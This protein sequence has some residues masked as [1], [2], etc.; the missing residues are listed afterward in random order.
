M[1]DSST[2]T[3]P[4]GHPLKY[5]LFLGWCILGVEGVLALTQDGDGIDT[6]GDLD[7]QGTYHYVADTAGLCH[8][9]DLEVIKL[10]TS[11]PSE[12]T[13][14]CDEFR[15]DL[16]KRDVCC[17][18]TGAAKEYGVG[19]HIIPY[20]RGSEWFRLIV[21][22][23]P[24]YGEQVTGLD[25]IN[26]VRNGMFANSLMHI[27]FN[28]RCVAILKTPNHILCVDDI[29]PRTVRSRLV[30]DVS[31]PTGSRYTLQWLETPDEF[32]A[33]DNG[34]AAFKKHTRM[35]KPSDLLLHYNYGAAAV[36][37]WGHGYEVLQNRANPPRPP[38][39]IHDRQIAIRK[40]DA[41]RAAPPAGP[42]KATVRA[43][44]GES[45]ESDAQMRWDED[46]VMLFCWGNTKAAK[47]RHAKKV[48]EN[49]RRMEQ[50]SEGV[51][52]VSV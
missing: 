26:G 18:W 22:N 12:S 27:S 48:N 44:A 32:I 36:K 52:R 13:N 42:R 29:P 31:Y 8:A 16:L 10:R 14:M 33:P 45:V 9:V 51:S 6:D 43:G 25:E 19:L 11:V 37:R 28:L 5:L 34:D 21:E 15:E 40:R 50:W 4:D 49:A 2:S 23:R 3:V 41:A 47:E 7:N 1:S 24:K 17:V 20:K 39:N 46:D 38:T 35:P 30:D